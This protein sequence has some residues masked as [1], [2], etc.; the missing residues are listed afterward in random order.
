ME[1]TIRAKH[2]MRNSL[3]GRRQMVSTAETAKSC[4]PTSGGEGR[5]TAESA[6]ALTWDEG[7][8][9]RASARTHAVVAWRALPTRATP[10][11]EAG[12]A[13]RAGSSDEA[14]SLSR[15]HEGV[16]A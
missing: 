14:L 12:V 8:D 2:A 16:A 9:W 1:V 10:T 6:T 4:E 3:L 11:E 15:T 7:A 5:P 13:D